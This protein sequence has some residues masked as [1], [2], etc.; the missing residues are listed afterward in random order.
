MVRKGKADKGTPFQKMQA[1]EEGN[2][3]VVGR[4]GRAVGGEVTGGGG[5]SNLFEGRKGY[6]YNVRHS[7][8]QNVA[9]SD[10]LGNL[11]SGCL[12]IFGKHRR[13]DNQ[14]GSGP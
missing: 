8:G 7:G 12:V 6:G 13:G 4:G 11:H 5:V 9:I 14:G 3:H 10:L 1:K 2:S